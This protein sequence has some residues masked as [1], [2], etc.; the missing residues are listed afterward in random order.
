M[1]CTCILDVQFS[2]GY[3]PFTIISSYAMSPLIL[4]HLTSPRLTLLVYFL[5]LLVSYHLLSSH[6]TYPHHVPSH[7]I[8]CLLFSHLT[9]SDLSPSH[10]FCCLRI[11]CL[12][13]WSLFFSPQL[14]SSLLICFH[15]PS[16]AVGTAPKI[17]VTVVWVVTPCSDAVAFTARYCKTRG[18]RLESLD[19]YLHE[20]LKPVSNYQWTKLNLSCVELQAVI[21][22]WDKAA[23]AWRL[24][25]TYSAQVEN[26]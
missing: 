18:P 19:R 15:L 5:S 20:Y 24:S 26:P 6:L 23:G 3:S 4:P 14:T 17:R 7:L 10:L 22:C 2:A 13:I 1:L 12:L 8:P 25:L 11:P 16:F 9:S 21:V